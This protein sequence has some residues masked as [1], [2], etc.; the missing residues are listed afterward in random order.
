MITGTIGGVTPGCRVIDDFNIAVGD[1]TEALLFTAV[2]YA[3][4]GSCPAG[5]TPQENL[6]GMSRSG[7]R[8]ILNSIC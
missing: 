6:L 3:E 8:P 4:T 1:P 7:E 2:A 5:T